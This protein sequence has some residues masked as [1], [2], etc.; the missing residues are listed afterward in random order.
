MPAD[1]VPTNHVVHR[2]AHKGRGT[3]IRA[4]NYVKCAHGD[5]YNVITPHA[6]PSVEAGRLLNVLAGKSAN[7]TV[8][9]QILPTANL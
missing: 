8:H 3:R 9:F 1:T 5:E 6:E 2:E 7:L 4:P